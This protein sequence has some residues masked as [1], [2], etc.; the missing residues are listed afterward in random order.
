ALRASQTTLT[1]ALKSAG[2][3]AAGGTGRSRVRGLLVMA[4][5]ALTV[6]LLTGAGLLLKSFS[7]LQDVSLGFQPEHLLTA[8]LP[9]AG[10]RYADKQTRISFAQRAI[11]EL[12][13]QPGIV[14][15]GAT[16]ALPFASGNQSYLFMREGEDRPRPGTAAA[17]RAVTPDYFHAM[18][19]SLLQG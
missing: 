17:F 6:V 13:A 9:L 19:V 11:E 12:R 15:L 2:Q 4:Q 5:M 14:E 1:D 16:S 3:G 10:Q 8:R 18:G 7:R